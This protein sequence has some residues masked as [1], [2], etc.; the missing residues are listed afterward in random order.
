MVLRL[1]REEVTVAKSTV[2]PQLLAILLDARVQPAL[3]EVTE[4]QVTILPRNTVEVEV[5]AQIVTALVIPQQEQAL[6]GRRIVTEAQAQ[7]KIRQQVVSEQRVVRQAAVAQEATLAMQR[8][9]RE[10][11]EGL[12]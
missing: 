11:P 10:V 3:Q 7:S 4:G 1:L 6:Q 2:R 12:A 8:I 9:V 5:E